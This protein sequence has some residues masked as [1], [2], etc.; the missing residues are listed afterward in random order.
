MFQRIKT[1]SIH[2]CKGKIIG[3]EKRSTVVRGGGW[4]EGVTKKDPGKVGE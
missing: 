3:K 2:S 1:Y 4:R